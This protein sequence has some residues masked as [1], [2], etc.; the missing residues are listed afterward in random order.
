M[1]CMYL[2]AEPRLDRRED[3]DT[4]LDRREEYHTLLVLRRRIYQLGSRDCEGGISS[5]EDLD[6][7]MGQDVF[8]KYY[9]HVAVTGLSRRQQA[10]VIQREAKLLHWDV[11][12]LPS[13]AKK[14]EPRAGPPSF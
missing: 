1:E 10:L 2:P 13:L 7:K 8:G 14:W 4:L 6:G 3:Y 9:V 11:I 5:Y 12:S